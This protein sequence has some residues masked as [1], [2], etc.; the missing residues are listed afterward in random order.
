MSETA[1]K[2]PSKNLSSPK[3]ATKPQSP[4][5]PLPLLDPRLLTQPARE[6]RARQHLPKQP[7]THRDAIETIRRHWLACRAILDL[8]I[9]GFQA[10]ATIRFRELPLEESDR[11]RLLQVLTQAPTEP[12]FWH[13]LE[14]AWNHVWSWSGP[15]N[16]EATGQVWDGTYF[17]E[18]F[19]QYPS[20]VSSNW[21]QAS[22]YLTQ[23]LFHMKSTAWIQIGQRS[24]ILRSL[25]D[26]AKQKGDYRGLRAAV[27]EWLPAPW[28]EQEKQQLR[29]QAVMA[30]SPEEREQ[31]RAILKDI[32]SAEVAFGSGPDR[33]FTKQMSKERKQTHNRAVGLERRQKENARRLLTKFEHQETWFR[34]EEKLPP[35]EARKKAA[36]HVKKEFK[37]SSQ[38]KEKD[39][40]LLLFDELIKTD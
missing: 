37:A 20:R 13:T 18:R 12:F 9:P 24:Q 38:A 34:N 1:K 29:R 16:D 27:Q 15:R 35:E 39:K 33:K 10:A 5:V 7:E 40:V 31:A 14:E 22:R 25:H 23:V 36:D 17:R 30:V 4:L 19:A 21:E 26:S 8:T 11:E 3:T 28:V 32:A 2:H 6:K